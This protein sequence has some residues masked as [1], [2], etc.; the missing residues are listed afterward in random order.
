[1]TVDHRLEGCN[2]GNILVCFS[3]MNNTCYRYICQ[4]SYPAPRS[5]HILFS[6]HESGYSLPVPASK[7]T[8]PPMLPS[9]YLT[10]LPLGFS[11]HAFLSHLSSSIIFLYFMFS[12]V[13][14]TTDGVR[15]DNWIY[16]ARTN[17]YNTA[18]DFHTTNY[19]A[20]NLLSLPSLVFVSDQQ[21]L[22]FC[23]IFTVRFLAIDFNTGNI[24]VTLQISLYYNTREVFRSRAKSSQADEQFLS[25]S[26]PIYNW[27]NSD[28]SWRSPTDDRLQ[29]KNCPLRFTSCHTASG[30]E[31][32]QKTPL[33]Y[34]W[35]R[36]S[37]AA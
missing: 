3:Y 7:H 8:P 12:R 11:F 6:F 16:W 18:V 33:M 37:R 31:K 17:K 29:L 15:I 34:R 14:V 2:S 36:V 24:T 32:A 30:R 1:V 21:W 20:L 13:L 35:P 25:W 4:K 9:Y 27:T 23:S 19:S 28:S 10:L 22:F 26:S 5:S